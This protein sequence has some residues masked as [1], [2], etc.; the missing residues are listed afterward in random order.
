MCYR[1]KIRSFPFGEHVIL[2]LNFQE[3][4][5]MF[6]NESFNDNYGRTK[7]D[8]IDGRIEKNVKDK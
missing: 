5:A 6:K 8:D 1:W 7:N 4:R 3:K 2:H